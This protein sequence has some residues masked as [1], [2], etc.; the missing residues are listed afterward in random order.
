MKSIPPLASYLMAA[1]FLGVGGL[2]LLWRK[3]PNRWIG[4]RLPWTFAD[5]Q[6]WDK[7]WRLGAIFLVGMGVGALVS[8]KIFFISL[9]HL[10]ILGLLYPIY[11]YWRKYGTLR[12]RKDPGRL[13]YRPMAKCRHCGFL[14]KLDRPEE[15]TRALC[16]E[17]GSGFNK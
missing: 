16:R 2:M 14:Q 17:C 10:L 9:A 15:L 5:R 13:D 6:I 4:V 3:G 1:A 12:Y 11:L 7:S 8:W